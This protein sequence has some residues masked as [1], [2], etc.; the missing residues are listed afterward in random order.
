MR[1]STKIVLSVVLISMMSLYA[2]TT[3]ILR[4]T[5][6]PLIVK[7]KPV[8]LALEDE[9]RLKTHN[10][11]LH[12]VGHSESSN[13]YNVVNRL[14][15]M[16]RYQFSYT[17][18]KAL[19]YNITRKEFLN[20]PDIQEEAMDR[21]LTENYKLLKKY[22]DK[23]DGKVV[24]GIRITKSGILAAAHLGGAGNVSRWFRRGTNFRD[25]NGTAITTY[26]KKFSNYNLDI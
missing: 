7:S 24:H 2:R 21:L 12:V 9:L 26:M 15:Y 18:L 3:I 6:L 13:R 17:T 1:K 10:G 8:K 23:Y 16:G 20:N 4:P 19:G 25:G 5:V 22:I 14:G 11:F